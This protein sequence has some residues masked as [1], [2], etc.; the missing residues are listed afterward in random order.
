MSRVFITGSTDGLG[1]LAA[2]M[3]VS[4]GHR[5]V[6][7]AR[8]ASRAAD[9]KRRLQ[10]AE[11]VVTGDLSSIAQTRSVADQ[12]KRLGPFDAVIHNAGAG[13]NAPRR[14]ETQD[15]LAHHFAV[16]TLGPYILTALIERPKRLIYLS[17]GLHR[18]ATADLSDIQWKRRP[19]NSSAAYSETKL[20]DLLL[21]FAMARYWPDVCSNAVDPG[22]M[23]TRMGGP[24]APGDLDDGCRTQAW[25]SISDDAA[26]CVSGKYFH[27]MRQ[28]APDPRAHDES[29]QDQLI[30]IC[31]R[32]SGVSLD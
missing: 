10:A 25:L 12:I 9:A 18:G 14:I 13:Y 15:G 32:L 3:L 28:Q 17:S 4:Q 27:F 8:D 11:A 20:H 24:H 23:P 2:K 5:V 1:L 29:L 19:W 22:W 16:N 6:L 7:H 26:A 31:A 21:A 30:E